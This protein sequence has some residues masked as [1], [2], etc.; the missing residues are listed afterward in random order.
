MHMQRAAPFH[1]KSDQLLFPLEPARFWHSWGRALIPG[2]S[3][4]PGVKGRGVAQRTRFALVA[5]LPA[6]CLIVSGQTA[7]VSCDNCSATIFDSC[8][9]TIQAWKHSPRGSEACLDL[10]VGRLASRTGKQSGRNVML[11]DLILGSSCAEQSSLAEPA[12]QRPRGFA[13]TPPWQFDCRAAGEPRA[14]S[15]LSC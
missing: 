9:C 1:R 13:V 2:A 11:P 4:K 10:S 5:L 7:F 3:S 6:F 14:P 15:F 8:D 12:T